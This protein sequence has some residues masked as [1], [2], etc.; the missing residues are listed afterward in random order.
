MKFLKL[1][2]KKRLLQR[3]IHHFKSK[4]IN[5]M[6]LIRKKCNFADI[7]FNSWIFSSWFAITCTYNSTRNW[8]PRYAVP[9]YR[10]KFY[11]VWSTLPLYTHSLLFRVTVEVHLYARRTE[12]ITWLVCKS[13][14]L[15]I[16]CN[17]WILCFTILKGKR[18]AY[19]LWIIF[20]SKI[21]FLCKWICVW[22]V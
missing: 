3:C 6:D 8:D 4:L 18:N 16:I 19:S 15:N 2:Y 22:N 11:I 12:F 7:V 20:V 14:K 9:S 5:N 10:Y 17:E 21:Y 13:F 1:K